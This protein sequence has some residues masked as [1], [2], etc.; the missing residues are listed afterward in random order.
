MILFPSLG[1]PFSEFSSLLP[2]VSLLKLEPQ[3]FSKY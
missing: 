3:S 1:S 2:F